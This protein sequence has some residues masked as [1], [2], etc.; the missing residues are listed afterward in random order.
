MNISIG[1]Y[2]CYRQ[3]KYLVEQVQYGKVESPG[4]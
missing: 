2:F 4:L 3:G 1:E